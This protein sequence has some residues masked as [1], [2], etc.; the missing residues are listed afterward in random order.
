MFVRDLEFNCGGCYTELDKTNLAYILS[1][2][3]NADLNDL[4]WFGETGWKKNPYD[5]WQPATPKFFR[6]L[7]S[8]FN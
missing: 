3:L 4:I 5:T 8:L 1:K 6:F 7:Q 2:R